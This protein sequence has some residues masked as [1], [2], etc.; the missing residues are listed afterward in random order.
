MLCTFRSVAR[1]GKFIYQS[2]AEDEGLLELGRFD[3]K[4]DGK[5]PQ[6]SRSWR[7]HWE[8][9]RTLFAYPRVIR[10]TIYT[11]NAIESL[12]SVIRKAIRKRKLLL[13]DDSA[14]KVIYLAIGEAERVNLFGTN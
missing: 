2:S 7:A 9:L 5:Y 6:I 8:S 12:S 3:E 14:L 13:S 1:W 4:W 11:T 10:R